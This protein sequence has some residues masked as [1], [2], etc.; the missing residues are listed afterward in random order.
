MNDLG[1]LLRQVRDGGRAAD[2][3]AVELHSRIQWKVRGITDGLDDQDLP[4]PLSE[5]D[6]D[7]IVGALVE[8]VETAELPRGA[9]VW[10]LGETFDPRIVSPLARVVDQY[11]DNRGADE[12]HLVYNALGVLDAMDSLDRDVLTR[13]GERQDDLGELARSLLEHRFR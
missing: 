4:P 9:V 7:R 12:T 1:I 6:L 2:D 3:A 10:A 13:I 8:V 11:A 5:A